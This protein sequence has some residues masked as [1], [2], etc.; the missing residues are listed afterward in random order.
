MKIK[1]MLD[2]QC[3]VLSNFAVAGNPIFL[4]HSE[5]EDFKFR[6][7]E[8]LSPLC[9]I[10]GFHFSQYEYQILVCLKDRSTFI[11]FFQEKHKKLNIETLTIPESTYIV[12]QEMA[13]IQSGYAKS[14]NFRHKRIGAVFAR[15]YQKILIKSEHDLEQWLERMH[16]GES[17]IKY[18]TKWRFRK[19]TFRGLRVINVFQ[20]SKGIYEGKF[21]NLIFTSFIKVEEFII[22]GRFKIPLQI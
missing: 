14:F 10:M 6:I 21:L 4:T 5:V 11:N 12:S 22:Q 7:N 18:S 20:N 9:E 13:N 15:R 16:K 19:R 3:Y 8:H 17:I 2:E 1:Y